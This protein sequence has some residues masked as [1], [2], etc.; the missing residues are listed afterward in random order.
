[1]I[2]VLICIGICYLGLLFCGI[3]LLID[4]I[5]Y[6]KWKKEWNKRWKND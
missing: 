6:R 2:G 3:I 5:R 1:M 4:T